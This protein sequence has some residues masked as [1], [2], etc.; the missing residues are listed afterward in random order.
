MIEECR[1][2][3]EFAAH[4]RRAGF[5]IVVG[6]KFLFGGKYVVAHFVDC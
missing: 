2:I 1:L 5:E 4:G 6:R 3:V